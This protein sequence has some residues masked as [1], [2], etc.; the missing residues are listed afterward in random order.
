MKRARNGRTTRSRSTRRTLPPTPPGTSSTGRD[1]DTA[2]ELPSR[3]KT[4]KS[5]SPG[6]RAG[7]RSVSGV[8]ETRPRRKSK[9][10]RTDATS[11]AGESYPKVT[12]AAGVGARNTSTN[13]GSG[14]GGASSS[15]VGGDSW[16]FSAQIS[17]C[18]SCS[19]GS[20]GSSTTTGAVF[21]DRRVRRDRSRSGSMSKT[22]GSSWPVPGGAIRI[23]VGANAIS[24]A[25]LT[26]AAAASARAS[27][28]KHSSTT[29]SR[30]TMRFAMKAY[31]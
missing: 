3:M 11:F 27:P 12:K 18:V 30:A 13:S 10:K 31:F 5:T 14:G 19:W 9:S 1:T 24:A 21:F 26:A 23:V 8:N 16:S 29:I 22:G 25:F 28:S 20:W 17:T 6:R 2:P 7:S 15:S 4:P